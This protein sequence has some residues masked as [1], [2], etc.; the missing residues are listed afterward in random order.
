MQLL[1][2]SVFIAFVM[3]N[4]RAAGGK[5]KAKAGK[6]LKRRE[7]ISRAEMRK[8]H[9]EFMIAHGVQPSNQNTH[10]GHPGAITGTILP[11]PMVMSSHRRAKTVRARLDRII[12]A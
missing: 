3:T 10:H 1:C 8:A 5:A 4:K 2:N 7:F 6:K 11:T 12:N 9:D